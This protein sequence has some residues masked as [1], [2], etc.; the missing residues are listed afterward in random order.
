MSQSDLHQQ[1]FTGKAVMMLKMA[2][3]VNA[4][5]TSL[6]IKKQAS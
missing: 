5:T 1:N 4:F 3:W 6:N 2:N